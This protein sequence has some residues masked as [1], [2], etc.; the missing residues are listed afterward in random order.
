[1]N[2]TKKR[3]SIPLNVLSR[4]YFIKDFILKAV[5]TQMTD[6]HYNLIIGVLWSIFVKSHGPTPTI[7]T[8]RGLSEELLFIVPIR[9]MSTFSSEI[10]NLP[11]KFL[12]S[13]IPFP[14]FDLYSISDAFYIEDE[15]YDREH[16]VNLISLFLPMN[17]IDSPWMDVLHIQ[18]IFRR[19]LKNFQ[20]KKISENKI[21]ALR[22][23]AKEMDEILQCKKEGAV[24]KNYLDKYLDSYFFTEFCSEEQQQVQLKIV[25]I[26][27]LLDRVFLAGD[28]TNITPSLNGI[29]FILEQEL[30]DDL[31]TLVLAST[32]LKR[33][34]KSLKTTNGRKRT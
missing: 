3:K 6:N 23:L 17:L 18:G 24:L 34:L 31:I 2:R 12:L 1:M 14:E 30:H 11:N 9:S 28:I 22:N 25:A 8:P 5:E 21:K 15:D 33:N 7:W 19:H 10:Y 27:R 26:L 4:Y 13:V 29:S 20:E 32:P 16:Q